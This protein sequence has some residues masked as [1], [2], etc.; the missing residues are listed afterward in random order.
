MRL[1]RTVAH[2]D[3]GF[4][5]GA[6]MPRWDNKTPKQ[7]FDNKYVIDQATGCWNWT[8]ARKE[9][10]Y[11]V[12]NIGGKSIKAHRLAWEIF[13]GKIPHHES[14]H[15][16]CVLHKCDNRACVNPDHLFLG[17][18]QEN[19][20]DAVKKGRIAKGEK[21]W[22]R[23]HIEKV[24]RGDNHP[25]RLHPEKVSRGEHH[26]ALLVGK[27]PCGEKHHWAKL[28]QKTVNE[29]RDRFNSGQ[30]QSEIISQMKVSQS[31]VSLIVRN[32]IWNGKQ[33]TQNKSEHLHS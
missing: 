23:F 21:H 32:K 27:M 7:R 19:L 33:S 1:P 3:G 14:F 16:M 20:T 26:S 10:G 28:T 15:G 30:K 31:L 4:S 24:R 9:N 6:T 13:K 17:T 18:Q 8:A 12:I 5:K 22:S 29:I 11:G 25:S 2:R